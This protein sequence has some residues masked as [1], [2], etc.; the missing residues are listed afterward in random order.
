[1]STVVEFGP[2]AAR[3]AAAARRT[4]PAEAR[5]RRPAEAAADA[6]VAA[7]AAS[8]AQTGG[9]RHDPLTL[10]ECVGRLQ[11][12]CVGALRAPAERHVSG[13]SRLAACRTPQDLAEA[14]I[15][16]AT[17]AAARGFEDAAR[18]A[19]SWARVHRAVARAWMG[20]IL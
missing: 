1:M 12:D 18:V 19:E 10:S 20:G 16:L 15:A 2:A 9:P 13:L 4:A 3:R 14:Q 8:S 17:E 11:R 5:R 7:A 6:W